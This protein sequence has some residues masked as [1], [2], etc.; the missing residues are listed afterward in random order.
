MRCFETCKHNVLFFD[1]GIQRAWNQ[2]TGRRAQAINQSCGKG[3]SGASRQHHFSSARAR[4]CR[5]ECENRLFEKTVA[6]SLT[7]NGQH[8]IGL[9]GV[10]IGRVAVSMQLSPAAQS[11]QRKRPGQSHL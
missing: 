7:L 5:W 4:G 8:Q 2:V 1:L 6:V 9:R 10:Q 3:G 11:Q